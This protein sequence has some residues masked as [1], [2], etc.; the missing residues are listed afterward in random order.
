[1]ILPGAPDTKD[2]LREAWIKRYLYAVSRAIKEGV[3]VRGFYYWSLMDNFE[4]VESYNQSFGLAKV[5]FANDPDLKRV[6][7]AGSQSYVKIIDGH[8]KMWSNQ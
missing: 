1:L 3:D 8:K 6:L 2:V 5:D 7:R 4:W